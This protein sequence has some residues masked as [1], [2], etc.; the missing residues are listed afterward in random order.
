MKKK[1]TK[2][3]V[4]LVFGMRAIRR[5]VNKPCLEDITWMQ[6]GKQLKFTKKEIRE[7]MMTGL[8]NCDFIQWRG[9]S[10]CL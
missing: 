7:W 9:D 5:M 1:K 4:D 6:N 2:I 10:E 3:D 8:N